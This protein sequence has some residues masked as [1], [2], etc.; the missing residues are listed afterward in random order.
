MVRD[1]AGIII[2]TIITNHMMAIVVKPGE[3]PMPGIDGIPPP[4]RR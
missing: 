4:E 2:A 1:A 3:R